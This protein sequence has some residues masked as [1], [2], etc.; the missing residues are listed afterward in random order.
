[1]EVVEFET[2]RA[3]GTV[4]HDG[5]V[6]IRG[7]VTF[8]AINE[9]QTNITFNVE[10]P[11]MDESMD[12]SFLTSRVERSVRNIKQLIESEVDYTQPSR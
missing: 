11:G 9:D 3:M 2:N 1:M 10:L 4:I 7:R 12:K 6:E 8:E 5:P